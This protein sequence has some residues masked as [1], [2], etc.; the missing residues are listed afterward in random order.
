[1]WMLAHR[2][3]AGRSCIARRS[4]L[5]WRRLNSQKRGETRVLRSGRRCRALLVVVVLATGMGAS[6]GTGR[7]AQLPD[8][9][10]YE[11]VSHPDKNGGDVLRASQRIRVAVDGSAAGFDSFIA[12]ADVAGTGLAVD[13]VSQ[14]TGVPGT[15]GWS[16]HAISPPQRAMSFAAVLLSVEPA[17]QNSFSADLSKGVVRAW[18]P[19]TDAPNVAEVANLYL[20]EDL[21]RAGP[22]TYQLV[23]S[24]P[25]CVS[26]FPSR[27]NLARPPVLKETSSDFGHILFESR[28]P[29]APDASSGL[30]NVYEWDHGTLRL[31]SILPDGTPVAGGAVAGGF[32]ASGLFGAPNEQRSISSDGSKV[33][34]TDLA[35]SN[36]YMRLNG[37]ETVQLNASERRA[38][39]DAPAPAQFY[40]ASTSGSRVFFTSQEALTNNAPTGGDR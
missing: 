3:L 27:P 19:L 34:F 32:R 26:P 2:K 28:L 13:Y 5:R 36:L 20:R 31:A 40:D 33:F 9:R 24:C 38:G 22:G 23:S 1:M 30:N 15:R 6:I 10:G 37:T 11:M 12:S 14:R 17:Y 4:R 18:S 21:R 25:V 8:G 7:A 39:A 16:V 29:L 35:T